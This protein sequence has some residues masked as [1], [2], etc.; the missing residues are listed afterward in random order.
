MKIRVVAIAVLI[1]GL[2][3]CGSASAI[4]SASSENRPSATASPKNTAALERWKSLKVTRYRFHFAP[5][6]FCARRVGFVTVT[7]GAVTGWEPD[8]SSKVTDTNIDEAKLD[9]LPTIDSL[10]AEAARAERE[11]TGRVEISYDAT[12]GA[13]TRASIDWIKE[14][15]DDESGWVIA[16]YAVLP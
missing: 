2:V 4:S 14:A 9:E 6:C 3:S 8:P 11:A 16:D 5:G 10:L 13:P 12:T 1:V 15:I 7:N